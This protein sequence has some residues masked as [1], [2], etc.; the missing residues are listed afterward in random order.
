ML[1]RL[2]NYYCSEGTEGIVGIRV[3]GVFHFI[4]GV[5]SVL[6]Q[7]IH[8]GFVI[9][10]GIIGGL[11]YIATGLYAHWTAY[12]KDSPFHFIIFIILSFVCGVHSIVWFFSL[13]L[14]LKAKNAN[15]TSSFHHLAPHIDNH[16][17]I[18]I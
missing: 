18:S 4:V 17:P 8:D 12:K 13:Y 11:I 5:I 1:Q 9:G 7:I 14:I 10:L 3:F 15:S 2:A 16:L 6:H